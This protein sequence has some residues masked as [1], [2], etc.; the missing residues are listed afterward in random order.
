[1]LSG[2]QRGGNLRVAK[3][4]NFELR[5]LVHIFNKKMMKNR[6]GQF[7]MVAILVIISVFIALIT[8][9]NSL[10]TSPVNSIDDISIK[11][12]IEKR[13]VLDYITSNDLTP[14]ESENIFINFSNSYIK[15][16]GSDKDIIFILGNN[17]NIKLIGQKT[18]NSKMYYNNNTEFTEIL[19]DAIDLDVLAPNNKITLRIDSNDYDFNLE[20]GQNIYYL[21]RYNYNE[22]EYII[23][24]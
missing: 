4:S 15:K 17:S 2:L 10:R 18:V 3:V 5:T 6:K 19:A 24:G 12:K 22:E 21:I 7:Y 23:N 16:I 1:V 8:V 11:I 13:E 14:L 9:N 20:N